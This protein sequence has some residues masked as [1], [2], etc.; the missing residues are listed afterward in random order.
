MARKKEK[1]DLGKE[2]RK[3]ARERVGKVQARKVIVPKA[4]RNPKYKKRIGET[5]LDI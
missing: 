3:L 1:F 2:V 5:G 4:E